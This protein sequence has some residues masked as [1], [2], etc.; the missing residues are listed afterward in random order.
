MLQKGISLGLRAICF[1]MKNMEALETEAVTRTVAKDTRQA[2]TLSSFSA[3]IH[4]TF[5]TAEPVSTGGGIS[6]EQA[7]SVIVSRFKVQ[8]SYKVLSQDSGVSHF[9]KVSRFVLSSRKY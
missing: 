7:Q 3:R 4:Q 8:M 1:S 2:T 5:F 6:L 9:V